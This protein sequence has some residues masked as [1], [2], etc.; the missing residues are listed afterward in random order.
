MAL[1]PEWE[2]CA[3]DWAAFDL[4]HGTTR[5]RMQVKH[6]PA[7]QS[8]HSDTCLPPRPRFSIAEKA[9]RWEGDKWVA[10]AG[11][12]ADIFVF[13]WHSRTDSEADHR[14]PDQW[15]FYVVAAEELPARKS[16]SLATLAALANPATFAT[17]ADTVGEC[18]PDK[19]KVDAVPPA[20]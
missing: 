12:N 10:E 7:R 15:V 3:G 11:R 19:L 4:R 17:L 8:W 13:G 18:V 5:L 6:S 2:L 14:D 20:P 1:E 9:G 16:I